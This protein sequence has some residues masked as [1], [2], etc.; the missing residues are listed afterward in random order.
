MNTLRIPNARRTWFAAGVLLGAAGCGVSDA[1]V[2]R[3]AIEISGAQFARDST[4]L[5]AVIPLELRNNDSI[6]VYVPGCGSNPVLTLQQ[7]TPAGWQDRNSPL[8][9]IYNPAPLALIPA[10]VRADTQR[11]ALVGMF[12][13]TV[14]YGF[15]ATQPLNLTAVGP[16]FT[17]R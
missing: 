7:W 13:Y 5:S 14:S 6:T 17:V 12:R 9:C 8:G 11:C 4:T 15:N 1:T 16:P 3:L 10:A 2:P